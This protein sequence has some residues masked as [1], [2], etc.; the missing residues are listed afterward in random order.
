[1]GNVGSIINMFHKIHEDVVLVSDSASIESADK[2]ILP[3]V[4]SFDN[5]MSKLGELGLIN[6]IK[7]HAS[8]GKL[9]L[10]ICLGMQLLGKSSEE[11][12]L[13]GLSLVDFH[14]QRFSFKNNIELK[15]PHMGWNLVAV[16]SSDK[17]LNEIE[18]L[19]RYYFVHSYH[20]VCNDNN[21]ILMTSIYGYEFTAAV[22]HGSVY[23]T[24]F[25]PEKSHNFGMTLLQN[26]ARL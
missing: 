23:G 18:D 6:P 15:V 8:K 24:Q 20:A 5:G 14:C 7:K 11:G 2:L 21:D 10:G 9:L 1:M 13:K 12:K 16:K 25:H 26:F 19:P 3:G 4:G 22:K 17:I